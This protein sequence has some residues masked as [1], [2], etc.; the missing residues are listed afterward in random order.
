LQ[1]VPS[2]R[3]QVPANRA[4]A[5]H[6]AVDWVIQP[7]GRHDPVVRY[8]RRGDAWKEAPGTSP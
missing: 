8:V 7:M 1:S 3:L 2:H 6:G 5:N 4:R